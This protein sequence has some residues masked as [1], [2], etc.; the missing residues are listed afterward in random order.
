VSEIALPPWPDRE[1]ATH[2]GNYGRVLLIGGC[3]GMAGAI[4]LAGMASLRAGAGTVTLATSDDCLDTVAG[5]HPA[6]MTL[7]L[8]FDR[9]GRIHDPHLERLQPAL[10]R[11]DVVAIGPGLGRTDSIR[12]LVESL[13]E[14]FPRTLV[15]DA[16]ALFA[17]SAGKQFEIAAQFPRIL[18]PHEGEF[19]RLIGRG[20]E[21]REE[22]EEQAVQLADERGV[23]L[24]LK[25][26]RTWITNGRQHRRNL[27]GNPGMATGGSGDVLTG[28]IS[29]LLGQ[30]FSPL[31]A[32]TLG[33]HLHGDAGDIAAERHTPQALIAT[34]LIEAL[35]EAIRGY[36]MTNSAGTS[37]RSV[38]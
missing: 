14:T 33:T 37:T 15:I 7:P 23:I 19:R 8:P 26:H 18:T 10:D 2:K 32:A 24:V 35:P 4:A 1:A 17:L 12:E 5:Y 28:V 38:R 13:Y 20:A 3:R 16:D 29:G 30:G 31:D 22:A 21:S 36:R 27:T 11:A 34:D 9:Q 25:G 6:Y